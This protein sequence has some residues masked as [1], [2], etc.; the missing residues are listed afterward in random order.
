MKLK[1]FIAQLQCS[2]KGSQTTAFARILTTLQSLISTEDKA[3]NSF[4][5]QIAQTIGIKNI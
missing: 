3:K 4:S 1:N 5:Q 2:C